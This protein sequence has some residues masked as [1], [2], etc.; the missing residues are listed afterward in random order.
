MKE[1]ECGEWEIERG[2]NQNEGIWNVRVNV[3]GR[4]GKEM[5]SVRRKR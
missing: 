1:G 4:K 3:Q 2:W 5:W